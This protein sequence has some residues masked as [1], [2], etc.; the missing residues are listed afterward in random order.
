[1]SDH[2]LRGDGAL[3]EHFELEGHEA[4][5]GNGAALA[6]GKLL[7]Q[8]EVEHLRGFTFTSAPSWSS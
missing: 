1:V 3:V 6:F 2:I 7:A 8:R 4:T 5:A